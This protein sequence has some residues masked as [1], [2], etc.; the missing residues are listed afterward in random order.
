[1]MWPS[2]STAVEATTALTSLTHEVCHDASVRPV[3][4]IGLVAGALVALV[5]CGSG[6]YPTVVTGAATS[7]SRPPSASR[8]SSST[9]KSESEVSRVPLWF[10]D[11]DGQHIS[12][13]AR[14][15]APT[16]RNVLQAL[17]EGPQ[18]PG[19]KAPIDKATKAD[20]EIVGVTARVTLSPAVASL[21]SREAVAASLLELPLV[22]KVEIGESPV[23]VMPSAIAAITVR[24]PPPQTRVSLTVTIS[25]SASVFEGTVNGRLVDGTGMVL[26]RGYSTAS[27]GAPGRGDYQLQLAAP[28][29]TVDTPVIAQVFESSQADGS[30]LHLRQLPLVLIAG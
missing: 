10:L 5:A 26:A 29:V 16:A 21:L 27:Q 17:S 23:M 11:S 4:P 12:T 24:N 22:K 19:L 6:G 15:L 8:A 13:E 25:G 14:D 9:S 2:S 1:M 30:L 7:V 18:S 20:V 28:R 3:H